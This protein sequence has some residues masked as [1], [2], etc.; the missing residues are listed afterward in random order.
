MS[1]KNKSAQKVGLIKRIFCDE[2]VITIWVEGTIGKEKNVFHLS[3]LNKLTNTHLKGKDMEG[4][5]I[6]YKSVKPFD[7]LVKK[8]Y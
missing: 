1:S 5:G 2:Y 8:I 6:E 3:E 7:Y 4:H